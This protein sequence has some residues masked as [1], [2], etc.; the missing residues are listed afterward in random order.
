MPNSLIID[1]KEFEEE[2]HRNQIVSEGTI[3]KK[4]KWSCPICDDV[5]KNRNSF[6]EHIAS[7]HKG[8]K[9]FKCSH[10]DIRFLH[11]DSLTKHVSSYHMNKTLNVSALDESEMDKYE[12]D[13][14]NKCESNLKVG[15]KELE[16]ITSVIH[17]TQNLCNVSFETEPLWM[18]PICNIDL[19]LKE[20]LKDHIKSSHQGQK[21]FRCSLCEARFELKDSLNRHLKKKHTIESPIRSD[22]DDFEMDLNE[23]D[24]SNQ[25]ESNLDIG[26][27]ELNVHEESAIEFSDIKNSTNT[28]FEKEVLWICP[29]CNI[30]LKRKKKLRDHIKSSHQGQKVFRCSLCEASFELKDSLKRHLKTKHVDQVT[31]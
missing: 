10:C 28:E 27:N 26:M 17:E 4:K 13:Y 9:P 1:S 24:I 29:I 20:K 6:R 14:S 22:V 2:S 11:A 5:F 15:R 7:V 23:T 21:V 25:C 19:K 3:M 8:K 18:C 16:H 12:L 30:D 31:N